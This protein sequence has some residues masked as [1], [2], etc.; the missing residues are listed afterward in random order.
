M[1]KTTRTA[2]LSLLLLL[3]LALAGCRGADE[4]AEESTTVEEITSQ[5]NKVWSEEEIANEAVFALLRLT[6]VPKA[7]VNRRLQ[8]LKWSN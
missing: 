1:K 3:A 6:W 4:P 2:L 5:E 7:S 8:I